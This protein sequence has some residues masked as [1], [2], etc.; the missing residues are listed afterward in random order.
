MNT[1]LI[2]CDETENFRIPADPK[3]GEAFLLRLWAPR[4]AELSVSFILREEETT[5]ELKA[6]KTAEQGCL[7]VYEALCPGTE[8]E[9]LY[10]AAVRLGEEEVLYGRNGIRGIGEIVPFSVNPE[11]SVPEWTRGAVWY[12]I[13]PE[14]FCNGD[15]SND[16]ET[17]EIFDDV[18][19]VSRKMTWFDPVTPLDV[20]HFYGGDLEGIIQKLDYLKELGVEVLYL[21]PIFVSPSSHKYNTQDYEHVDPHFGRI[22]EDGEGM[23]RYKA[24][25]ASRANLE[26]SDAI[27]AKLITKAHAY[28]IRV[29][30]D[31]VFNHC[32]NFHA[33]QNDGKI[34]PPDLS[35]SSGDFF[36]TDAQGEKECW[37]GNKNLLKLNVD[38]SEKL[39]EYLLSIAEKWLKPP[40]NADGWRLDVAADVGHS[41]AANH[42]FWRA[43]RERVR[44]VNPE[45][46]ILAEHYGDPSAWLGGG[47][48]DSVM[49]YDAFMDPLSWF[50][51]GMEKHS[52]RYLPWMEGA[53]EVFVRSM[54][55]AMA[56]LPRASLEAALC[57]LDNHDHSR[58]LTRTN[59]VVGRLGELGYKAAE[60]GTSKALLRAAV[61]IQM[62]WPGAPGIYY[63]DEAGMYGFTDPDNRRPY[64]WGR[65]DQ[66]MIDYY[67]NL[68][69]LRKRYPALRR[70]SLRILKG[71][72]GLLI[73]ARFTKEECLL[74]V[75]HQGLQET[76][77]TV[78]LKGIDGLGGNRLHR[79]I[80]SD[81]NGYNLGWEE[82][83]I[84]DGTAELKLTPHEADLYCLYR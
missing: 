15:P 9:L 34:Y 50:L 23:D 77:V 16:V 60:Q 76:K 81:E 65:E 70:G 56:K 14:R 36:R 7:D 18:H 29:V 64:P 2:F 52:D 22:L 12:Q 35:Q 5:R 68:I 55:E 62:S 31:G 39:R 38:G 49:N 47:E 45:A 83:E 40:Y 20:H 11:L 4:E 3:A 28:G 21:N 33:W 79:L 82:A 53:G 26:A 42:A 30:L 80:R 17:G 32:S 61:L 48:W 43:F 69:R 44:S 54:E 73:F 10:F 78:D 13:F 8:S 27:L 25:T 59:H 1:K 6:A 46:V 63:G 41:E 75:V 24:R 71:E 67:E 19:L 66:G 84:Q 37:W 51:T 74:T 58:F 72:Q 57:Q